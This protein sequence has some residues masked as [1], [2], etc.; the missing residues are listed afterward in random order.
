M[1]PGRIL[2]TRSLYLKLSLPVVATVGAVTLGILVLAWMY[3]E[4]MVRDTARQ[5][6]QSLSDLARLSISHEMQSGHSSELQ[7][8]LATVKVNQNVAAVRI[9]SEDGVVRRSADASEIGTRIALH[10]T[11]VDAQGNLLVIPPLF[12]GNS[13]VV[14]TLE[15][16]RNGPSCRT[17]HTK[18]GPVIG[19]L[20][21]DFN[22][23]RQMAAVNRW[24]QL[25]V[26]LGVAQLAAV[27][28]LIVAALG[29]LV[30]RPIRRLQAGMDRVRAH[31]LTSEVAPAGN[32]EMDD[33]VMGFNTMIVRLREA[34]HAEE[35]VRRAQIERAEQLA[36]VG[37]LAASLAHEIR[38]P[39][40]G[41]KA[42]L[43]VV[44]RQLPDADPRSGI[45]LQSARELDRIESVI[46]DLLQYARPHPPVRQLLALNDIISDVI[47]L[48]AEKAAEEGVAVDL[49][50]A[51][52]LPPVSA[53]G[54]MVRQILTNLLLNAL[55]ATSAGSQRR[56]AVSTASADGTVACRIRDSGPGVLAPHADAIFGAFFTTKAR[57]TGL[58]LA[59]SRR[60]AELQGG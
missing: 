28:M 25:A 26:L 7:S 58:G 31:D 8:L 15:P 37:Q 57:G 53:D 32:R 54:R 47:S 36:T 29:I 35:E 1:R 18:A 48:T 34:A 49:D 2:V 24:W 30:V 46:R 5:Y 40:S 51:S 50:L 33:L 45:L 13:A 43:A 10:A 52:D 21:L 39:L 20:D 14:H 55:H 27:V 4:R 42:A 44:G 6:A 3:K 60:F 9:L 38:N 11:S 19:L 16:L 41:V 23:S 56:I 17:C 59:I 22:V 12:R